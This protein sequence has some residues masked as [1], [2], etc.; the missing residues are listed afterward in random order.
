MGTLTVSATANGLNLSPA[1]ALDE[2]IGSH[3]TGVNA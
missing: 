2:L 1:P 3:R